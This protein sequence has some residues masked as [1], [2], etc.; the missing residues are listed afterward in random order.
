[1]PAA[2][3]GRLGRTCTRYCRLVQDPA[4]WREVV[5][6]WQAIKK[7]NCEE[8]VAAWSKL[9]KLTVTNRKFEQVKLENIRI[10]QS[11]FWQVN[12]PAIVSVVRRAGATLRCLTFSS[13]VALGSTAVARLG[14]MTQLTSL[15][16]PGDWVKTGAVK[17]L[18]GLAGLQ[19]LRLPGAEQLTPRD[20]KAQ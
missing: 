15:E 18:A 9:T 14:S 6:D 20:T 8:R 16:L 2:G 7:G 5:I 13:E 3:R 19:E 12:S 11:Y 1:M 4:L 10:L 17:E